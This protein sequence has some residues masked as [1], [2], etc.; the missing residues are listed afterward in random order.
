MGL[1]NEERYTKVFGG[2]RLLRVRLDAFQTF[3]EKEKCPG[4]AKAISKWIKR[5]DKL[6]GIISR[7]LDYS[8]IYWF[9]GSNEECF[10]SL[11]S[12]RYGLAEQRDELFKGLT[13][14]FSVDYWKEE[15]DLVQFAQRLTVNSNW[16]KQSVIALA[17]WWNCYNVS[18]FIYY[19]L[20]RY[21]DDC[22]EK[23][24]KEEISALFGEMILRRYDVTGYSAQ[25]KEDVTKESKFEQILLNKWKVFQNVLDKWRQNKD[26]KTGYYKPEAGFD[27]YKTP[28]DINDVC[29]KVFD[30]NLSETE[31]YL[32]KMERESWD[33]K[34]K[35]NK[36]E[37]EKD[38]LKV[39]GLVG[40]KPPQ[41]QKELETILETS[42]DYK[43]CQQVAKDMEHY[44]GTIGGWEWR[45]KNRKFD[46]TAKI[47][48]GKVV[49]GNKNVKKKT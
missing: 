29:N 30:M 35:S 6:A 25:S 49:R 42:T 39:D 32:E 17:H 48:K 45:F 27:P 33:D 12:D 10:Q 18:S 2:L 46:P 37:R 38:S 44:Y 43:E 47:V 8:S 31:E 11:Y 41:T 21:K 7:H 5:T 20:Y 3:L 15:I 28:I 22:F 4:S 13:D 34:A 9:L 24:V 14:D 36:T 26:P 23:D 40:K 16:Q 19:A 1:S